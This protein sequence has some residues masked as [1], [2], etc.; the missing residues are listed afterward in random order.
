MNSHKN[1][2]FNERLTAARQA[3]S[4]SLKRFQSRPG[5]DD[6]TVL[7]RQALQAAVSRARDARLDERKAARK[8]EAA[9]QTAEQAA[10]AA[11]QEAEAARQ[12]AAA[13][14]QARRA[15]AVKIEQ[16]AARDARY[17]ARNARRR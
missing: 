2:D 14:E 15:D 3:K 17:A 9:R 16:K 1:D 13:A 8:V 4:A 7:R 6:P 12:T 5:P 11:A 10:Q